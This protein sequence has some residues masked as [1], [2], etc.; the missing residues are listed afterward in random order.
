[1]RIA[2]KIE[3][4]ELA[5]KKFIGSVFGCILLLSASMPA[6]STLITINNVSYELSAVDNITFD[7]LTKDR[8]DFSLLPWLGDFH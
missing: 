4:K 5:M 8:T 2:K 1:L 3:N 7:S 6:L